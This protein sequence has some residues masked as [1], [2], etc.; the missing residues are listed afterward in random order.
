MTEHKKSL[1]H[2][3]LHVLVQSNN[4]KCCTLAILTHPHTSSRIRLLRRCCQSEASTCV[5]VVQPMGDE[6]S[7]AQV[8]PQKLSQ[9]LMDAAQERGAKLR[10]GEVQ[11]ITTSGKKITGRSFLTLDHSRAS[12]APLMLCQH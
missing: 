12:C 4:D 8:H 11:N 3:L 6:S 2:I 7:T 5:N 1:L 10:I 9:A